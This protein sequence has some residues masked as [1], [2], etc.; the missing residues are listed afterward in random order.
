MISVLEKSIQLKKCS[1]VIL[2]EIMGF[3]KSVAEVLQEINSLN[4][5]LNPICHCLALL[6]A[7]PILHVSRIRVNSR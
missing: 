6:G 5:K 1:F 4:A 3:S 7:H 2:L